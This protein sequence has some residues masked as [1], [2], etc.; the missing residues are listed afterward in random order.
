M[1]DEQAHR[2]LDLH[3]IIDFDAIEIDDLA[4]LLAALR[5]I[6]F[7]SLIQ[8]LKAGDKRRLNQRESRVSR[9][10]TVRTRLNEHWLLQFRDRME[11]LT[12]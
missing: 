8:F 3:L 5:S 10:A 9:P 7:R 11:G 4:E 2:E 12:A 1:A 6:L